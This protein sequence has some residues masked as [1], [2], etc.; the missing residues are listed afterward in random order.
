MQVLICLLCSRKR[1]PVYSNVT[2]HVSDYQPLITRV[3][4]LTSV[5]LDK[6]VIGKESWKQQ[7]TEALSVNGGNVEDAEAIDFVLHF[8]TFGWKVG[9]SVINLLDNYLIFLITLAY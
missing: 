9:A 4:N 6:L 3:A 8:L 7:F 1:L 5:N 2:Q